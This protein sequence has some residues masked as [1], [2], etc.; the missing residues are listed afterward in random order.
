MISHLIPFEAGGEIPHSSPL[1]RFFALFQSLLCQNPI[2]RPDKR[3]TGILGIYEDRQLRRT[4]LTPC[5]RRH[6]EK[7]RECREG[8]MVV[9]PV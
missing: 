6:V 7:R 4:H 3:F 2:W 5:V 9:K 1:R 8:S